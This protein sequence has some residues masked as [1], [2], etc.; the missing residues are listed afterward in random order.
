MKRPFTQPAAW[1]ASGLL[2]CIVGCSSGNVG[3]V[4]GTVHLDGKP[5]EGALVTFYPETEGANPSEMGTSIGRTD[6]AGKYELIYN[7]DEMGAVVGKH[8]VYIETL[9]EGSGYGAGRA[10]EVPK[11][12]NTQSELHVEVKPGRNTIDFLELTSDGQKNKARPAGSR[13]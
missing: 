8:L 12:Y 2:L 11:R 5:L 6:K 10:E 1:L 4:S 9:Q 7:R 13:Y 3:L